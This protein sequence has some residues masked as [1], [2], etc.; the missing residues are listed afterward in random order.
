MTAKGDKITM[1]VPPRIANTTSKPFI[2]VLLDEEGR[3]L[4]VFVTIEL[5]SDIKKLNQEKTMSNQ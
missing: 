5:L 2:V 1:I 4:F 3:A